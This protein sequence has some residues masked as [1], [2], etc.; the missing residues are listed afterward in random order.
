MDQVSTHANSFYTVPSFFKFHLK[1]QELRTQ[2]MILVHPL[3][4]TLEFNMMHKNLI[5]GSKL[6]VVVV[7]VFMYRVENFSIYP[8]KTCVSILQLKKGYQKIWQMKNRIVEFSKAM[9][10][11]PIFFKYMF[12]FSSIRKN[13]S[14]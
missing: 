13:G 12:P 3:N 10:W 9:I 8:Y 11:I 14:L 1:L 5:T 6:T 2:G 7:A 4:N